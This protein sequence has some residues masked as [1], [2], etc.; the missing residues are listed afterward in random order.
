MLPF[1]IAAIAT[2]L[3]SIGAA[4]LDDVVEKKSSF[5]PGK[6]ARWLS[7]GRSR[8]F[9]P[10]ATRWRRTLNQLVLSFADQQLVTSFAL[11]ISGYWKV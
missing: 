2:N 11:V 1:V 6:T 3:A 4:I 5:L 10:R 8:S 7:T 9:L